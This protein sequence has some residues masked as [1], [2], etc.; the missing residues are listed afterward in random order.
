[1]HRSYE[2]N[3]HKGTTTLGVVCKDGV[4]LATD[5]RVTMGYFIA[6]KKGKKV[7]KIDNHLAMTIAGVVAD[8]QNVVEILKANAYLYKLNYKTIKEH[9]NFL[10]KYLLHYKYKNSY[11]LHLQRIHQY[12]QILSLYMF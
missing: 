11:K 6:H 4:A 8:A 1:M 2:D 7:H 12:H 3:I 5:T 10:L 9:Y